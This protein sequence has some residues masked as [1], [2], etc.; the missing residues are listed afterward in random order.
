[1]QWRRIKQERR[2]GRVGGRSGSLEVGGA[3][4]MKANKDPREAKARAKGRSEGRAFQA[5]GS[6][7]ANVLGWDVPVEGE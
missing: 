2:V 6:G 4:W 3:K 1:M 5:E 7:C